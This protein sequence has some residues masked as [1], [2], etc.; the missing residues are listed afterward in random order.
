MING[1]PVHWRSTLQPIIAH[2]TAEAE[3]I[4]MSDACR[5]AVRI[6][7]FLGELG[8]DIPSPIIVHEDNMTT[9][10][11][12]TEVATKRSKHIDIRYHHVRNLT[13]DGIIDIKY[14][15]TKDMLADTLTKALP[16]DAFINLRDRFMAKGEC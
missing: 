15:P 4:A 13:H 7:Q 1:T 6:K 12:A 3:Y 16:K 2:S 10:V 11:I 14:C 9:R 5:D 8:Y